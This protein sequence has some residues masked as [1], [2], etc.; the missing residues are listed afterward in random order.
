MT[1]SRHLGPL[2]AADQAAVP[3]CTSQILDRLE[4]VRK[5]TYA[6]RLF[7]SDDTLDAHVSNALSFTAD[8]QEQELEAIAAGIRALC[9]A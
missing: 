1:D 6:L 5:S 9:P 7:A 2:G 4:R 3:V 8:M